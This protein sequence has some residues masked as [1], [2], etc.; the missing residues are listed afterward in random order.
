MFMI[1]V[2]CNYTLSS[3][4]SLLDTGGMISWFMKSEYWDL[5][6]HMIKVSGAHGGQLSPE[7]GI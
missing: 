4:S 1:Y 2:K 5:P 6:L 3:L 7:R